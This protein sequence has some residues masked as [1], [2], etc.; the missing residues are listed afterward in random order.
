MHGAALALVVARGAP[1]QLGHHAAHVSAFG[2][3]VAVATMRRGEQIGVMQVSANARCNSLLTGGE[4]QWA[5]HQR[6]LD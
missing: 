6:W 5:A 2:K 1:K 4:M 3:R